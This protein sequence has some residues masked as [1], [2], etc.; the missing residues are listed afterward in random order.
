VRGVRLHNVF[1]LPEKRDQPDNV[2]PP[3]VFPPPDSGAS[4]PHLA[5]DILPLPGAQGDKIGAGLGVIIVFQADR[6]AVMLAF[7]RLMKLLILANG[8]LFGITA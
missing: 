8:Q 2:I 6:A 4:H 3:V 5:K 1:I 7:G